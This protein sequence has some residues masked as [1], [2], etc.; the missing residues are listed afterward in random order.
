MNAGYIDAES[1]HEVKESVNHG[2]Y[3]IVFEPRN[4]GG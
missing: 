4:D 2:K 3:S 1:E